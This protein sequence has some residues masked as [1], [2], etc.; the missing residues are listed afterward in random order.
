MIGSRLSKLLLVCV[1]CLVVLP[2]L[3]LQAGPVTPSVYGSTETFT[4]LWRALDPSGSDQTAMRFPVYQY[5]TVRGRNLGVAGLSVD[6][7]GFGQLEVTEGW[8]EDRGAGDL[9]YGY[10]R[11]VD[12][13]GWGRVTAGR[14]FV[15]R[16]AGYGAGI[17]GMS[18]D[19]YLPMSLQFAAFGGLITERR[20]EGTTER[21][22][23]GGRLAWAPWDLGHVAASYYQ[24]WN[25]GDIDRQN[26]GADLALRKWKHGSLT[27]SAIFDM[28]GSRIQDVDVTATALVS[29]RFSA[30][31]RY[32][33]FDPDALLP[34]TSIFWVFARELH[35]EVG[36]GVSY[37]PTRGLQLS[38]DWDQYFYGDGDGGYLGKARASYEI[39]VTVPLKV[40]LEYGRLSETENGYDALRAFSRG[41]TGYGLRYS[42]EAMAYLFQNDL[43]G[44]DKAMTGY[45]GLGYRFIPELV[46]DLGL[47]INHT[48]LVKSELRGFAKLTWSFEGGAK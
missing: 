43:R 28:Y 44:Y 47:E 8:G 23:V 20:F 48:P 11:Y 22:A 2:A 26:V 30:F 13:N 5:V 31:L 14:Q 27:S 3:N 16:G 19:L 32:G 36:G 24:Q 38:L 25:D 34:R 45:G 17:D 46:L 37:R 1:G 39:P 10:V 40:G 21:P 29:R 15:Y 9:L 18:A 6:V 12:P 35:Q 7:S 4:T 41:E 42:A 33:M